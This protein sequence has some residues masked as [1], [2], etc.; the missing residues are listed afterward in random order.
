MSPEVVEQY[1]NWH[2]SLSDERGLG[3]WHDL[4]RQFLDGGTLVNGRSVLEIGCGRGGFGEWLASQGARLTAADFSRVAVD[5]ARTRS[6]ESSINWCVED[7]QNLSFPDA[8]FDVVVSCETIEHVPDSRRAVGE[9]ARVL[10]PGGV[11]VLTCPNYLGLMGAYRAY[12]HLRGRTFQE[13]GQPINQLT[14]LPLTYR[15]IRS[16]G[17]K[18]ERLTTRGHYFPF[19]G[20]PPLRLRSL[21]R[22]LP[23]RPFGLHSAF[24]AR[25]SL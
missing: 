4:A 9:L 18:V 25:K 24:R 22:V 13:A 20:R 10:R 3:E 5:T 6:S 8:H 15:W 19:P 17:L 11:L 1:D 14:L 12:L 16:A 7:I 21:E 2:T 23:L